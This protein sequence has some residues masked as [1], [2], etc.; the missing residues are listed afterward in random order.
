MFSKVL[1]IITRQLETT[2]RGL[3]IF[4]TVRS[5]P[6]TFYTDVL[7]FYSNKKSS[8]YKISPSHLEVGETDQNLRKL[9]QII[10]AVT[11]TALEILIYPS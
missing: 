11:H 5:G 7:M 8:Y 6:G 9:F 3:V 1:F 2:H 4:K 10:A